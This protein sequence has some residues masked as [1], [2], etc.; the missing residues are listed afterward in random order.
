MNNKLVKTIIILALTFTSSIALVAQS[1]CGISIDAVNTYCSGNTVIHATV[2]ADTPV[3]T[4][5]FTPA[6]ALGGDSFLVSGYSGLV[7]GL[8]TTASGCTESV[9]VTV[10]TV[11][12]QLDTLQLC[13]TFGHDLVAT[14]GADSYLWS[15]GDTN[16]FIV[17]N[18]PGLY[19]C[20]KTYSLC[21]SRN[22][23][24]YVIAGATYT[25]PGPSTSTLVLC[26]GDTTSLWAGSGAA[27]Y[28]WSMMDRGFLTTLV[29]STEYLHIDTTGMYTCTVTDFCGNIYSYFFFVNGGGCYSLVWPGD[30]GA[31]G[32]AN[33]Y[34]F[35]Y[36]AD[37]IGDTGSARAGASSSWIGQA[38]TNWTSFAWGWTPVNS[39]HADCDGNGIVDYLD[40]APLIAN[41][42]SIHM[43]TGEAGSRADNPLIPNVTLQANFDTCGINTIVNVDIL[44]GDASTPIDSISGIV[45]EFNFDPS[46][47]DTSSISINYTG[48]WLGTIGSNMLSFQK[49][50]FSNARLDMG[51][52]RIDQ[53]NRSGFGKLATVSFVTTDNLSGTAYCPLNIGNYLAITS[54]GDTVEL[55]AINDSLY[56]DPNKTTGIVDLEKLNADI[57]SYPNPT[58][59]ML[60]I[61]SAKFEIGAI[62]LMNALGQMVFDT[63][64]AAKQHILDVSTFEQGLYILEI[65]VEGNRVHKKIEINR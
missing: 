33:M 23:T 58:S 15:N 24:F 21:S 62:R 45:L 20:A 48:S 39:K 34:D 2:T 16:D 61:Q 27:S 49:N 43:R 57:A 6:T 8:L 18:S 14:A 63:E 52:S 36:I 11:S 47:V 13:D 12:Y 51:A 26:A 54:S 4:L 56:I 64:V 65:E 32:I 55:D 17:V 40:F 46:L 9:Y 5:T 7:Y 31:D 42:G 29:D 19:W 10:Y 35:L 1:R 44:L 37:A 25:A 50:L 60:Y 28:V 3:Y 30:A 59:D 53:S 38:C 41:Y 22:D